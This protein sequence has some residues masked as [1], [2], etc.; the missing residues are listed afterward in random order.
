MTEKRTVSVSIKMKPSDLKEFLRAAEYVWPG[1]VLTQSGIILGLARI[2]RESV[3][4][5]AGHDKAEERKHRESK[6]AV[7]RAERDGA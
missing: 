4:A 1:A 3:L 7:G 6:H 2:G 5:K